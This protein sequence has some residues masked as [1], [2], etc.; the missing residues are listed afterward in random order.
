MLTRFDKQDG[1][2]PVSLLKDKSNLIRLIRFPIE[3][4]MVPVCGCI[5]CVWFFG[6]CVCVRKHIKFR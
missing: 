3:S 6:V 5:M 4:G 2:Y 1:I